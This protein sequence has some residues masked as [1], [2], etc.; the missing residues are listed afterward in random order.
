MELDVLR[1]VGA[2]SVRVPSNFSLHPT[3]KRGH[4]DARLNKL[5]AGTN[6]DWSTAESLAMAS[7]LYQGNG[8]LFT[9]L[10]I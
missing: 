2:R 7:L 8:K 5:L 6:L 9:Y 3:L 1:W 10:F 4:V